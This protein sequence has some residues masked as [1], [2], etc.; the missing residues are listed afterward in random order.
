VLGAAV[1]DALADADDVE[2]VEPRLVE[3]ADDLGDRRFVELGKE[4][5]LRQDDLEARQQA[6]G[7]RKRLYLVALQIELEKGPIG[8]GDPRQEEIVE[9]LALY[10]VFARSSFAA[11]TKAPVHGA[12]SQTMLTSLR[13]DVRATG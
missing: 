6:L 5:E 8:L 12:S 11:M 1:S 3:K 13:S 7:A 9:R 4:R 2:Q 10:S